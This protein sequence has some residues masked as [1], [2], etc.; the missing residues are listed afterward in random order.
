MT[1]GEGVID[2]R[3]GD[4]L[5]VMKTLPDKSVDAVITDPPYGIAIDNHG[6]AGRNRCR[7]QGDEDMTVGLA[8]LDWAELR[9][10]PTVVFASPRRQWPGKWRNLVVWDKGGAVGGGGDLRTCLKLSWE[11]IQI[12][13]NK[14]INGGRD[15]SVWRYTVTPKD[16]PYHT[17]EKPLPLM[18]RL[19]ETF[20]DTGDTVLDPFMGS[21][22]TGVACVQTG[23]NFIGIEIDPT[24]FAIAEKRINKESMQSEQQPMLIGDAGRGCCV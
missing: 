17:C 11:L 19:I 14:V 23:R 8:V 16:F 12:A 3:L 10:L 20:T 15:V 6:Q 2:L 18:V 1:R 4:C 5:E 7:I 13:R 24:Y 21:G 22:T 9:Q